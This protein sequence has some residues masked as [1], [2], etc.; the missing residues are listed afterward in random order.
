MLRSRI[1]AQDTEPR[2]YI[3]SLFDY[4]NGSHLGRWYDLADYDDAKELLGAIYQQLKQYDDLYG[5]E[6][7]QP[8]E[9]WSCHDYENFPERL[10][11][12]GMDFAKVY[13]YLAATAEMDEDRKE[14]YEAFIEDGN[15]PEHFSDRY[16]GQF[17][18]DASYDEERVLADYA[19]TT[20]LE[21]H[22]ADEI[23]SALKGYIDWTS[24]GR[25]YR[26]GGDV[27]TSNGHVFTTR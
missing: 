23:P 10:Y 22:S 12:E 5:V 26:L 13:E 20:W 24:L 6:L 2:V 19:E 15:E 17:G 7:N 11:S 21:C 8:R 4:N 9:E 27:W 3:A 18:G 25:D 14:A 1:V 16:Q